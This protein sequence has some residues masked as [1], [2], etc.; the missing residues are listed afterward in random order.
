MGADDQRFLMASDAGY[1]FVG[2]FADMVS[3]NKAGKAYLSL[4]VAAKVIKP[5]PVHNIET[6]W[7]LSV[8]SEGRMLLFPLRDLPSLGKGKGNK[9]IN[10]PSAKAQSREEY[11][12]S[13]AVVPDG[14]SIKIV[15]GKRSMTLSPADLEHYQGERGRR[16]NKLPRGLQRVDAIDVETVQPAAEPDAP[17]VD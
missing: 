14:A 15:A 9:L 2:K 5:V 10:I 16:G 1:G 12:K 6:D 17:E 8:S 4:P 13:L 7:C 11:V 3:K